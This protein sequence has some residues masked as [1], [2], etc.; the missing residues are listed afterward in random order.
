MAGRL[1]TLAMGGNMKTDLMVVRRNS[2][3]LQGQ[4]PNAPGLTIARMCA[5][6][7]IGIMRLKAYRP[8]LQNQGKPVRIAIYRVSPWANIKMAC[9]NLSQVCR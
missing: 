4:A 9:A 5:G 7:R 3:V 1:L 2:I 8:P 6:L